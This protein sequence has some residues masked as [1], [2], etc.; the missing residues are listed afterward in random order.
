MYSKRMFLRGGTVPTW[1]PLEM[2]D[3]VEVRD[4][5]GDLAFV[6]ADMMGLRRG[7]DGMLRRVEY[8]GGVLRRG[9][10]DRCGEST[11]IA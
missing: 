1:Q 10:V 8:P 6:K 11:K 2:I 4:R 3:P 9:V 5:N 7:V